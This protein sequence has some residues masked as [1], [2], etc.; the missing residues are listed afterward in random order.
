MKLM[1]ILK[2][3]RKEKFHNKHQSIYIIIIQ[4]FNIFIQ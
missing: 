4:L 3:F 2:I 1:I